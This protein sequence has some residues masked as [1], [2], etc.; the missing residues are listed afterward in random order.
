MNKVKFF[1]L[2]G[3]KMTLRSRGGILN[4]KKINT[5]QEFVPDC[6]KDTTGNL[7]FMYQMFYIYYM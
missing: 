7:T 2:T 1:K 5:S 6:N 4:S 3:T